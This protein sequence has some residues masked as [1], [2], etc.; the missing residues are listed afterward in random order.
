MCSRQSEVEEVRQGQVS[1]GVV[2]YNEPGVVCLTYIMFFL[3]I[4]LGARCYHQQSFSVP[5]VSSTLYV[6][7]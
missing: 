6:H 7:R 3:R 2:V 5:R 4:R 1:S